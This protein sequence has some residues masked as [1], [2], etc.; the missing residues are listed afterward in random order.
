MA[1]TAERLGVNESSVW[2]WEA[3]RKPRRR[4]LKDR[5]ASFVREPSDIE[6]PEDPAQGEDVQADFDL[7]VAIRAKRR[8]QGLTQEALAKLLGVNTWTVLGWEN[9]ERTPMD[10]FYPGL[11]RFLGAE[12]WAEPK[13]L[14]ARLRAERLRRGLSQE[15][16]AAILQVN[17]A[18]ISKWE[19]GQLP[20][21]QLSYSKVDAFLCGGVRPWRCKRSPTGPKAHSRIRASGTGV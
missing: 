11:I 10:R 8:E 9:G 16:T 18:S 19:G 21:H 7:C 12:P 6:P 3:G 4:E 15:Q 20:R 5:L 13:T 1:Q 14:A 17:R 2:W